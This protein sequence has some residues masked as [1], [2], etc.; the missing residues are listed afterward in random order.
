[1]STQQDVRRRRG[2]AARAASLA[3]ALAAV[4]LVSALHLGG[5]QLLQDDHAGHCG[6]VPCDQ[7]ESASTQQLL[8]SLTSNGLECGPT[9]RRTDVVVVERPDGSA[10]VATFGQAL[11]VA[12]QR[13]GR[14]QA[15]CVEAPRSR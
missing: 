7:Q 8:R 6:P 11:E 13:D 5:G 9:P 4:P 1:M 12:A 10:E 3:L 14:L 2:T 15:Y